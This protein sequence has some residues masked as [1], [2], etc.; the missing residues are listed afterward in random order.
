MENW[1][2]GWVY[3][4]DYYPSG[5]EIFQTGAGSNGGQY[6]DPT[7]DRLIKETNFGDASLSAYEN[8]LAKNLPVVWQPETAFENRRRRSRRTWP[9]RRPSTRFWRSTP[10]TGTSLS[11]SIRLPFRYRPQPRPVVDGTSFRTASHRWS[12]T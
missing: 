12:G 6:S 1:G 2:G 7:N 10:K 8:Y 5:E 4:P 9:A 3:S 11:K